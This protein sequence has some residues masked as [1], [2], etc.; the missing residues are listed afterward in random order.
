MA[1]R[2]L[3]LDD[4]IETWIIFL[5][6]CYCTRITAIQKKNGDAGALVLIN[7]PKMPLGY[8]TLAVELAAV[9][10]HPPDVVRHEIAVKLWAARKE[11]R[12][13]PC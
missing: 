4:S 13:R 5:R 6:R 11:F 7:G 3:L 8:A 1:E 9:L 10:T 12:R 2:I